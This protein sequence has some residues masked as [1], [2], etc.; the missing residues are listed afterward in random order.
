MYINITLLIGTT[1]TYIMSGDK[2]ADNLNV[3]GLWTPSQAQNHSKP[4]LLIIHLVLNHWNLEAMVQ[5]QCHSG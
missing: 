3:S 1:S 4:Y 5:K 2:L